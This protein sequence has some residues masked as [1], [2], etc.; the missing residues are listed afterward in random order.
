[1]KTLQK[2]TAIFILLAA[3]TS[4]HAGDKVRIIL[5]QPPPNKL[6]VGDMW[7]LELTNT[8][9]AEMKIYL[10][11]T[12]TEEKDG[13]IIEG[14]TKVFT[15]K[16]GRSTYKY[17]DFSGAEIKYNNGKYKEIILRTGN[18][19][20]GSYTICVTAFD[21][22]GTEVGRENCI[23]QAVQQIGGITLLTPGD[24]EEID[25]KMPINFTWTPLPGAK[26]YTLR[27]VELKG[28]QS[29]EVALRTNQPIFE[30]EYK[31]TSAH[32]VPSQVTVIV[33]GMKLAWQVT[34][35][36]TQSEIRTV[37]YLPR[38]FPKISLVSPANSEEIDPDTLPGLVFKWTP[39]QGAQEYKLRIVELKGDQ[40][41][42]VA[43]RTNRPI[44]E[45]DYRSNSSQGDPVH[46]V[47]VKLGMK[48]AWRVSSGDVVS[49]TFTYVIRIP[50]ADPQISLVS[51]A[52]GEEIDPDTLPGIVFKWREC[53]LCPPMFSLRIVEIKGDQSP[54]EAF[55]TN[56]PIIDKGKITTNTFQLDKELDKMQPGVK[57]AWQVSGG[58]VQSAIGIFS[59]SPAN[60]TKHEE[61]LET[62]L[63]T[64]NNSEI[65]KISL[66]NKITEIIFNEENLKLLYN[67]HAVSLS[68]YEDYK[69]S[70][71]AYLKGVESDNEIPG[72]R[73]P[74]T[75]AVGCPG[76]SVCP[77]RSYKWRGF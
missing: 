38:D 30:K 74:W 19:P 33:M 67:K 4:L 22:S 6:G 26:E 56:Q 17:N 41:P 5:S 45:K 46:G 51:P 24:G 40:S 44:L 69:K 75:G 54:E 50:I 12:A 28:D 2:L 53:P 16:P 23:M 18:A 77:D 35:G 42:E 72:L 68:S 70:L 47:D 10:T 59:M 11:G 25:P 8:T 14:R 62:I 34:S 48:Y 31:S 36:N 20:E 43:F 65:V 3:L 7:N 9:N 57:Y 66:R 52:N 21:E 55:R 13:L 71:T 37:V 27:I 1:M 29:P 15:I 49:E 39:L 60:H 73:W 61:N 32:V 63:M 76:H 64:D 58:D